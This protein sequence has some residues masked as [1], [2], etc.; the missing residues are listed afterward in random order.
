MNYIN[1]HSHSVETEKNEIQIHQLFPSQ[2]AP[3]N[4]FSIGIHPWSI[5]LEKMKDELMVVESLM[6]NKNCV[7]V[8][9]CGLDKKC[10]TNFELQKLIFEKQIEIA[11]KYHK[12]LILHCVK[13]FSE[14][15]QILKKSNWNLPVLFHGFSGNQEIIKR[16][17]NLD[18]YYSF[19][20]SLFTINSKAIENLKY[21]KRSQIF[22]ENDNSEIKIS[23]VYS[24]AA[25]ILQTKEEDL[26]EQINFN[27][28]KVFKTV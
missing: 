14:T 11:K 25:E 5:K 1:L 28:E 16:Y 18:C 10:E 21:L 7:A 13:A 9:E 20:K 6:L 24:K 27:F 19:G 22:F 8:G 23:K 4:L 3:E 15:L 12:P 2:N 17:K 26:I